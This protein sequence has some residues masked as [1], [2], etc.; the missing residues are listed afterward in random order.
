MVTLALITTML[1]QIS[2]ETMI[3]KISSLLISAVLALASLKRLLWKKLLPK[4]LLSLMTLPLLMTVH[5]SMM[6][7]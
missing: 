1:N 7:L 3:P 6:T 4:K 2:A 5:V